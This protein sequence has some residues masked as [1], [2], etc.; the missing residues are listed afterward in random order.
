[1]DNQKSRRVLKGFASSLERNDRTTVFRKGP[2]KLFRSVDEHGSVRPK[3]N[4][5]G[6]EMTQM[7]TCLSV[8]KLKNSLNV[9]KI[10]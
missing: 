5:E 10:L 4:V 8:N 1:M 2:E 7:N 9:V 6:Y 3:T